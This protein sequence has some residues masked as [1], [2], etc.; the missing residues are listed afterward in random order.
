[1]RCAVVYVGASRVEGVLELVARFG[2]RVALE[3]AL[4]VDHV[5]AVSVAGPD[6]RNRRPGRNPDGWRRERERAAVTI[7]TD[8]DGDAVAVGLVLNCPVVVR[9][10]V[11]VLV[12]RVLGRICHGWDAA[13]RAATAG[14]EPRGRGR[15]GTEERP[16]SRLTCHTTIWRV[17]RENVTYR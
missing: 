8:V 14:E 3:V 16:P 11:E 13:V 15:C 7:G 1:M 10:L 4:F 12:D 2:R 9:C 17:Q 6:P 5:V